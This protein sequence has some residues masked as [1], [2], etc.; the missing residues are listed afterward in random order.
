MSVRPPKILAPKNGLPDDPLSAALEHEIL[1]EKAGTYARLLKRLEK[2]MQEARSA[3]GVT[4]TEKEK[5]LD[6]AGQ[7]LWYVMIQRDLCGFRRHDLFFK[8][9]DIPAAV[10]YR[11]GLTAS[12]RL[13]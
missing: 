10:R 5:L 11:M 12:K 3:E 6:A 2:A 1:A 8:E 13:R 9:M 7:A 4:G